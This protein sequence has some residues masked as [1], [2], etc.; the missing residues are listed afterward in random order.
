MNQDLSFRVT[1]D[2][3]TPLMLAV[4]VG[5]FDIVKL[6]VTNPIDINQ[7][8]DAGINA[9]YVAAYYGRDEILRFLI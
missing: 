6:L 4:Q 9:A 5:S 1:G 3:I 8:D 2:G 7:V